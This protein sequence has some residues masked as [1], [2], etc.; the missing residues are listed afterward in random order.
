MAAMAPAPAPASAAAAAAA[1]AGPRHPAAAAPGPHGFHPDGLP[2]LNL[3]TYS[4]H[5]HH[6]QHKQRNFTASTAE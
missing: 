6:H 3:E 1:V 5:F 2:V 4:T